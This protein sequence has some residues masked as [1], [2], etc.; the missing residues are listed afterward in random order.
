[1]IKARRF[2]PEDALQV[3]ALIAKTMQISN[4]KDY[5]PEVIADLIAHFSRLGRLRREREELRLGDIRFFS[6]ER[7]RLG[8]T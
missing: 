1:M 6:T 5:P 2:E 4:S 7:G 8:F 3:S